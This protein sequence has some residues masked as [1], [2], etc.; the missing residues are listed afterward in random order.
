MISLGEADAATVAA[1]TA[2]I[3]TANAEI[4]KAA[5]YTWVWADAA[6]RN[7]Q[8]VVSADV[9]RQG[10]QT[11]IGLAYRLRAASG[12]A[13]AGGARWARLDDPSYMTVGFQLT[14]P[15]GNV[16][17]VGLNIQQGAVGGAIANALASTNRATQRNK[18]ALQVAAASAGSVF[19]WR[20]SGGAQIICTT[21]MR[22][23]V[24]F[25]PGAVVSADMRYVVGPGDNLASPTTNQALTTS[26]VLTNCLGFGVE[27]GNFGVFHN[28]GS[29]AATY[30]PQSAS[31]P[32]ATAN[33]LY[34]CEF[35]SDDGTSVAWQIKNVGTGAEVSSG[36][37]PLTTNIPAA[38]A[39]LNHLFWACNNAT[40]AQ[41]TLGFAAQ[42]FQQRCD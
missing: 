38:G 30:L 12:G 25:G 16:N 37:S 41:V 28:D 39:F 10:F 24:I 3:A 35:W 18:A 14:T 29:G 1:N 17:Q 42:F 31:F 6:A 13:G 5:T 7:A 33:T 23:R 22:Y 4:I 15:F 8:A 27:G 36:A 2:A 34:D 9:G 21:G 20:G 32:P 19:Y 11:D 40:A 26:G